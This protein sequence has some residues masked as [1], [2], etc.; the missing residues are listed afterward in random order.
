MKAAAS[1][2][3][4]LSILDGWWPEGH[5]GRNGWAIGAQRIYQ[6]QNLQDELDA[7]ALYGMLEEE[8]APLYFRRD[9]KGVPREWLE[10]VRHGLATLAPQFNS[11]RMVAEYRDRAYLPGARAAAQLAVDR[12]AEARRQASRIAEHRRAL[13]KVRIGAVRSGD[14]RAVRM[15]EEVPVEAEVALDGARVEDVAVELVLGLSAQH[16]AAHPQVVR[17]EA[18]GLAADGSALFGASWMP[19][20]PGA[21]GYGVRV[22]I[23][24]GIPFEIA[25]AELTVWA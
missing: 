12:H 23:E 14:L 11:D 3:L 16:G 15:G 19:T 17:L 13:P 7:T 4:N 22:R 18:R 21:W 5:D 8:I 25:A 10:R 9:A 20:Q 1:G 24:G 6:E 2:A